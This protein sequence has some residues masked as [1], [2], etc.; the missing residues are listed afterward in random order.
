MKKIIIY[1]LV[2]SLVCLIFSGIFG[3]PFDSALFAASLG[4][5]FYFSIKFYLQYKQ[6]YSFAAFANDFELAPEGNFSRI[7]T[8]MLVM[9]NFLVVGLIF[10][11]PFVTNRPSMLVPM[12]VLYTLHLFVFMISVRVWEKTTER[13]FPVIKESVINS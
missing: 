12:V 11:F 7:Q 4:M 3:I 2:L 5:S 1:Q 13:L 9:G 6:F 8:I 10:Y